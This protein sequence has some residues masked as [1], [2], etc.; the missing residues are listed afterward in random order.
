MS[1][2]ACPFEQVGIDIWSKFGQN[3][4]KTVY[5]RAATV[6]PTRWPVQVLYFFGYAMKI[7]S[8]QEMVK[9]LEPHPDRRLQMDFSWVMLVR[10]LTQ[11]PEA[12]ERFYHARIAA[13]AIACASATPTAQ[14]P[15][16]VAPIHPIPRLRADD[17]SPA[18]FKEL[19]RYPFPVVIE[20]FA[21]E[22]YAV[23]HW[24]PEYFR[25]KYGD[26][27]VPYFRGKEYRNIEQGSMAELIDDILAGGKE[28]KYVNNIADIFHTIPELQDALPIEKFASFMGDRKHNKTQIFLGGT[29]TGTGLHC[30]NKFN[31]FVM[32]YGQKRWTFVHPKHSPW[33]YPTSQK[34][35]QFVHAP[36]S[37]TYQYDAER[38][39]LIGSAPRYT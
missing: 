26:I 11:N 27:Q 17:V 29:A 32:I 16:P 35:F 3:S 21:G 1:S 37:A 13:E 20:N 4:G 39:P 2:K 25:D 19:F 15:P 18:D 38:Y 6:L 31:L 23:K 5:R 30:A 7:S 9:G 34:N 22:S 12:L 24:S 14:A 36:I 33:L 8:Q 10:H 28:R